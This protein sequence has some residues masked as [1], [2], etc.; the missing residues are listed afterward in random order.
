MKVAFSYRLLSGPEHTCSCLKPLPYE[1]KFRLKKGVQ[2]MFK[3]GFS[4][5]SALWE[6]SGSAIF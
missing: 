5:K 6:H 3:H 4:G 2:V 1:C